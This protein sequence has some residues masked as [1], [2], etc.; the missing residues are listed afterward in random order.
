MIFKVGLPSLNA[1][2]S[3]PKSP[4]DKVSVL[5]RKRITC[6]FQKSSYFWFLS[7]FCRSYSCLKHRGVFFGTPCIYTH[8]TTTWPC[9]SILSAEFQ[10]S[11]LILSCLQHIK[12]TPSE[13]LG[14]MT[15]FT[16]IIHQGC[17]GYRYCLSDT[18]LA[19]ASGQVEPWT[20]ETVRPT[21]K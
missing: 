14:M 16:V 13:I 20:R 6:R 11:S 15:L 21:R 8:L 7:H 9:N 10:H 18:T 5:I 1:F 17:W 4:N 12:A 2:F 3:G 19:I